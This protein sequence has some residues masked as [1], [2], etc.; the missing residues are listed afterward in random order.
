MARPASFGAPMTNASPSDPLA[1]IRVVLVEPKDP[2]NIAATVRAIANMGAGALTL[3]RPRVFEPERIE[4][5]A[6]DTSDIVQRIRVCD[7]LEE[8]IADC[9]RV[10][11]YTA[12]RRAAKWTVRDPREDAG[13]MLDATRDGPVAL[14]FGREDT[15]LSNEELERAHVVITIPTTE[16]ASLNLAQAVLV[17]LYELRCAARDAARALAPPRKDAPPASSEQLE[18]MFADAERALAAL[19]FFRTR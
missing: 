10:A 9:V 6:H 1:G 16:R 17:A 13:A 11:G 19:D 2:V 8:A 5:V 3:V 14:L 12:R 7:T 4:T 15:G 18:R